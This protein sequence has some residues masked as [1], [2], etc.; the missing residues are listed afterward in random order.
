MRLSFSY[1]FFLRILDV[2]VKTIFAKYQKL[3]LQL[4]IMIE[5][6]PI[7]MN[8]MFCNTKAALDEACL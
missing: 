6:G 4:E 2:L 3:W 5:V 7:E 8:P 1:R